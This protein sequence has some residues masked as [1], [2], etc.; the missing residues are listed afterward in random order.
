[1][2]FCN[3]DWLI[4]LSATTIHQHHNMLREKELRHIRSLL[5]EYRY[6]TCIL[7]DSHLE[8]RTLASKSSQC[9]MSY[10]TLHVYDNQEGIILENHVW[11][12]F[13]HDNRFS[14]LS[15]IRLYSW[16]RQ[17]VSELLGLDD[18]KE[19]G[20]IRCLDFQNSAVHDK[21]FRIIWFGDLTQKWSKPT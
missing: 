2:H 4:Y 7:K 21:K 8:W 13:R 14:S 16:F 5:L 1:M 20:Q 18:V 10:D 3:F 15:L 9:P 19:I 6:V 17:G 11:N 12:G